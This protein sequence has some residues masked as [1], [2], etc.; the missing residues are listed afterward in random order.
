MIVLSSSAWA[1]YLTLM[2]IARRTRTDSGVSLVINEVSIGVVTFITILNILLSMDCR[3][4]GVEQGRI[5]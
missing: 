4:F 1:S 3:G 5:A 2:K